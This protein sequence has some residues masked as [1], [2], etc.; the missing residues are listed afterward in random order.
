MENYTSALAQQNPT[1]L[2]FAIVSEMPLPDPDTMEIETTY[3]YGMRVHVEEVSSYISSGGDSYSIP[4]SD[5]GL[6]LEHIEYADPYIH[7]SSTGSSTPSLSSS[8]SSPADFADFSGVYAAAEE[9][10]DADDER[11]ENEAHDEESEEDDDDISSIRAFTIGIPTVDSQDPQL[12]MPRPASSLSLDEP[13]TPSRRSWKTFAEQLREKL[14]GIAT[15]DVA[16]PPNARCAEYRNGLERMDFNTYGQHRDYLDGQLRC[17]AGTIKAWR[18]KKNWYA[19]EYPAVAHN[20]VKKDNGKSLRQTHSEPIWVV[21][22]RNV[23]KVVRGQQPCAAIVRTLNA[24][25]TVQSLRQVRRRQGRSL[26][27]RDE[28]A[29]AADHIEIVTRPNTPYDLT[30]VFARTECCMQGLGFPALA[31]VNTLS[32]SRELREKLR[33]RRSAWQKFK[34]S[35]RGMRTR[36]SKVVK[37]TT[38]RVI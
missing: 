11:E 19:V 22:A 8:L 37:P 33:A 2:H 34:R 25:G 10:L 7:L 27:T 18:K 26:P 5:E 6:E 28:Y 30:R 23:V 29:P 31:P 21:T 20:Y 16:T 35:L 36:V 13:L 9:N 4:A 3:A 38:W 1:T 14:R 12:L 24:D 32:C 15:A 17:L